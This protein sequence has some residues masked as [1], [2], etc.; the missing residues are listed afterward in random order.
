M[1]PVPHNWSCEQ[2]EAQICDYLDGTLASEARTQFESHAAS[3]A[4]CGSM[5]ANVNGLVRNLRRLEPLVEPPHLSSAILDATLG[6]R[7]HKF[8][9][10]TWLGWLRPIA[11]PR[12]TYGTVS[13][14][15]TVIVISHALGIQWRKPALA[16]LNPVNVVHAANRQTHQA[17]A[18]SVK[19]VSDL[20]LIYEIQTRLHP[21]NE[22]EQT[23]EPSA[24]TPGET[25]APGQ[26]T[27]QQLMNRTEHHFPAHSQASFILHALPGR[28]I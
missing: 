7:R 4:R 17:Y 8:T 24:E 16:D 21:Q 9:W 14:L 6:P 23:A 22:S 2:T 10:R 3:C 18:R 28:S 13:V 26:R 19:F 27:P 5:L 11:Q 15:V 20:R 1:E 12:F 25:L